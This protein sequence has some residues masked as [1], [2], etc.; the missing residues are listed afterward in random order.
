MFQKFFLFFIQNSLTAQ[1]IV[2]EDSDNGVNVVSHESEDSF[3][4][5]SNIIK[6]SPLHF[7]RGKFVVFDQIRINPSF[8]VEAGAGVSFVDYFDI[9]I[10]DEG[11]YDKQLY[12]LGPYIETSLNLHPSK[13]A[14]LGYYGAFNFRYSVTNFAYQNY[15][16]D[17]DGESGQIND[18]GFSMIFGYQDTDWS[19]SFVYDIYAGFGFVNRSSSSISYDAVSDK[20]VVEVSSSLLPVVRLGVKFGMILK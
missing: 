18:A 20:E 9:I 17:I 5:V 11:V 1:V 6:L 13:D 10:F 15:S 12:K 14:L 8:S 3:E 4:D 16:I 2:K 7:A 19:D